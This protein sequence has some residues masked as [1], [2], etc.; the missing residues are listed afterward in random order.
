MFH[1][2]YE[3]EPFSQSCFYKVKISRYFQDPKKQ[4]NQNVKTK[5]I[6]YHLYTFSA[7]AKGNKLKDHTTSNRQ[8]SDL[9][10]LREIS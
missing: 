2:Y 7:G 3:A 10:T 8:E 4:T 6:F 1:Q 9:V 5:F